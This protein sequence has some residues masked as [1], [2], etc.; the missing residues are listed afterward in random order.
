MLTR[1]RAVAGFTPAQLTALNLDKSGLLE[2]VIADNY[3]GR[4]AGLL[5]EFQ[6]AFVTFLLGQSLEGDRLVPMYGSYLGSV[7]PARGSKHLPL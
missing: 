5:A 7:Y 1:C 6:Y 4:E 3:S 2:R